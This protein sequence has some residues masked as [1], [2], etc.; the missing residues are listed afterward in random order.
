MT[1]ESIR[2]A[3]REKYGVGT[4]SHN[5][6]EMCLQLGDDWAK[7]T[8]ANISAINIKVRYGKLEN[9]MR[10]NCKNYIMTNFDRSKAPKGILA[11]LIIYTM[12]KI[13]AGWI[14]NMIVD[15]LFNNYKDAQQG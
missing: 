8:G 13:I 9:A 11:T 12:L 14:A 3:I 7:I 1:N 2:F 4:P 10:Q 5:I 15:S 6:S